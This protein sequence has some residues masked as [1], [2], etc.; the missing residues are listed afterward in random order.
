MI[1]YLDNILIHTKDIS[2]AYVNAVRWMLNKLRKY[3]FFANLK[4]CCFYKDEFWFLGY[5]VSAKRVKIE[6]NPIKIVKNWP[7]PKLIRDIWVFLGFDNFY[8]RFI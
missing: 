1:V 3:G 5:V 7:E 6:E 2:Q 8:W 4:K